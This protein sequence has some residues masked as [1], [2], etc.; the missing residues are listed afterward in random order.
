MI[1]TRALLLGE[2]H[3]H[4]LMRAKVVSKARVSAIGPRESVTVHE[5]IDWLRERIRRGR[6]VPG[7]RLVE[8]DI[9]REVGA[10]RSRVREALQRLST[11]GLVTIEEFRGASV[12]HFTHDEIRQIYRARMAL[13][14]LAARDFAAATAPELKARLGRIQSELNALEHTGDHERFARLNDEWHTLIIEGSGNEYIR[15]F[16]ERLRVPIY[17]LL[18][19]TFYNAQRID[20]A[21][22]GHRRISEAIIAGRAKEAEKL[23]RQH[24][25][26]GLDAIGSI[27]LS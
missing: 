10:S 15:M 26:E 12:K 6:L 19:T 23:M 27:D 20:K 22:A 21:N 1:L 3:T 2:A 7:Q 16:V 9:I 11:E 13:E 17:R 8:A 4:S 25:E 5:V 14:G 18:F 24:I